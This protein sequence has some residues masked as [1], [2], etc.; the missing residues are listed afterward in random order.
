MSIGQA[1]HVGLIDGVPRVWIRGGYGSHREDR[2]HFQIRD[3]AM[4]VKVA[5]LEAVP[6]EQ[7]DDVATWTVRFDENHAPPDW[8]TPECQEAAERETCAALSVVITRGHW[9]GDLN[10]SA[11]A[12]KNLSRMKT[13]GGTLW[14]AALKSANALV[15]VG[16]NLWADA[17][18]SANALVKVGGDLRAI[19]LKSAP[20][21]VKVGGNLRAEMQVP[22][23]V[24][25]GQIYR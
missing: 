10:L 22:D 4:W 20:A 21:L 3:D 23:G 14:A 18:E 19:A 13:V 5:A 11:T 17:L 24:V 8:W 1:L 6:G 25:Q 12:T 9:P 7:F 2:K 15:K 16:G